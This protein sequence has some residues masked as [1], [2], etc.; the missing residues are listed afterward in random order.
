MVGKY[1]GK[2]SRLARSQ[3]LIDDYYELSYL[4]LRL[5]NRGMPRGEFLREAFS[6][7]LEFS[8]C[9]AV[10]FRLRDGDFNYY[11]EMVGGSSGNFRFGIID[12]AADE[13]GKVLPY[14][15]G[16]AP[17]ERL[18]RDLLQ[19][20]LEPDQPCFTERG[21]FWTGATAKTLV[22]VPSP[23]G[24]TSAAAYAVNGDYESLIVAPFAVGEEDVGLLLLKSRQRDFFGRAEAEFYEG[25]A[26]SIGVA[27]ADRRAHWKL[28][29]R[30]KEMTC[31][32]GIAELASRPGISTE[33]V[34]KGIVALLPPAMQYPEITIGRVAVDNVVHT[35]EDFEE[36]PY[37]LSADVVVDGERRGVVEVQYKE[38]KRDYEPGIFLQE[39]QSLIDAIARQIG[40]ILE[41]RQAEE[42]TTRLQ[43]QL[44]HADRLATIGQLAAG[45]AHELNE[46]LASV[47]SFAELLK[48][49]PDLSAQGMKD[50][51][52]ILTAALHAREVVRKLLFFAREVPTIKQAV[53][54]SEGVEDA[55]SLLASRFDKE[56]I[57]CV[58][59]L[60]RDLP[61]I[62]ADP[63][64]LH[65]VIVNLVVNAVQAMPGGGELTIT[66]AADDEYVYLVVEDT[67]CGMNEEI[68]KNIFLPFFTTK[69]I[70]QGTG[71]GLPVVH[72]IVTSHGGTVGVTSEP[73][74]GSRFEVRLPIRPKPRPAP[75]KAENEPE[76]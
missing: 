8:G 75:G 41:N 73:G 53:N 27:V 6:L 25:V 57:A 61:E 7:L 21:T 33:E 18:C 67:G 31:L 70:G 34:W 22:K 71:L 24:G 36:T 68:K 29:E 45:V 69:E 62:V 42:E 60:A 32:Y 14:T 30:V 17:L 16:Q 11:A 48:D 52:K 55:L 59:N 28:R 13:S 54:L 63:A 76:E 15:D 64:Q 58:P 3:V 12:G 1:K 44:R 4:I 20:R 50:L 43:E 40:L 65:Q 9:D 49:D 38:A 5:G 35:T 39:E 37:K 23:E 47:L 74:R 66:T 72:G 10:E 46:P 2:T 51:D 56:N 19:G 26:Q